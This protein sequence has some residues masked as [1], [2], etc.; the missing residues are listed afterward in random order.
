[1]WLFHLTTAAART[2]LFYITIGALMVVWTGVW[3]VYLYNNPPESHSIYYWCTGFLVT[4][5]TLVFIGLG[6]DRIGRSARH[7]DLPPEGVP[8][9]V[10]NLP[11]N[12]AA[13][14]PVG[15][16]HNATA[17]MVAPNGQVLVPLPQGASLVPAAG[18]PPSGDGK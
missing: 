10:V 16:A 7:A 12:V 14:A 9:T 8:F 11:P 13:P 2:A 1:M 18:R 3:Y 15:A 4:G 5:L 17:A 6:L